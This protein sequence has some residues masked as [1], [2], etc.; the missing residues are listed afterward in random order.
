[1]SISFAQMPVI[2][3]HPVD[4]QIPEVMPSSQVGGTQNNESVS[5][6]SEANRNLSRVVTHLKPR[7]VRRD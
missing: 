5:T 1:M 4:M 3:Y 2:L 6:T 7:S